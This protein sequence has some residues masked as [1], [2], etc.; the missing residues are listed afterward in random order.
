MNYY[1]REKNWKLEK[2]LIPYHDLIFDFFF[3]FFRE[4]KLKKHPEHFFVFFLRSYRIIY[5]SSKSGFVFLNIISNNAKWKSSKSSIPIS[6]FYLFQQSF[7]SVF[8]ISRSFIPSSFPNFFIYTT[9]ISGVLLLI[10]P[11]IL[12]LNVW[13]NSSVWKE[14]KEEMA[15]TQIKSSIIESFRVALFSKRSNNSIT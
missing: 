9:V 15:A 10:K 13:T 8:L 5:I 7:L 4:N 2:T 1:K 3:F 11:Y 12:L 14:S 6:S